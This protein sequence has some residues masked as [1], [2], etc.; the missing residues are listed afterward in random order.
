MTSI[1]YKLKETLKMDSDP[2]TESKKRSIGFMQAQE[3]AWK[4]KS[5]KDFLVYMDK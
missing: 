2:T 5:K 3:M 1:Y 4:L